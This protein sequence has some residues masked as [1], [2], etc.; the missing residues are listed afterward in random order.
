MRTARTGILLMLF[1]SLHAYGQKVTYR[2]F[3]HYN[4]KVV[5]FEKMRAIDSTDIVMLGNSLTEFGGDWNKLLHWKHIRNRGIAGDDAMGIYHRLSQILP[6]KPKAIFLMVG[7]NDLSHQLSAT[8]VFGLC[9][10]VI[11]KIDK[12]APDTRLYV[13]SILPINESFGRWKT[14]DGQTDVV[15][16]INRMLQQYCHNRKIPYIDLFGKF[17]RK[18]THVMR[19]SLTVDGLHLTATGYK[20]WGFE[21]RKYLLALDKDK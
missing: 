3:K 4:E 16:E 13:Q 5:D 9:K 12:E 2:S 21:L 15:S 17:V 8:E 19:K 7:I 1:S 18:G 11:D 14:L 20:V 10:K 6:G